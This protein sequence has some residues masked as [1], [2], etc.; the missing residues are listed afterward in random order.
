MWD[1]SSRA[2]WRERPEQARGPV[3]EDAGPGPCGAEGPGGRGPPWAPHSRPLSHSRPGWGGG[4]RSACSTGSATPGRR[5]CGGHRAGEAASQARPGLALGCTGTEA[6][7]LQPDEP[8]PT[9]SRQDR[10]GGPVG[11]PLRPPSPHLKSWVPGHAPHM[12][13]S[14]RC[15][16]GTPGAVTTSESSY[17]NIQD[18]F[19]LSLGA[20]ISKSPPLCRHQ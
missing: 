3:P 1:A 6:I 5:E 2:A 9:P 20:Q 7:S 11:A 12:K 13:L 19:S 15:R 10:L 4:D 8:V 14:G 17:P 18:L 16:S